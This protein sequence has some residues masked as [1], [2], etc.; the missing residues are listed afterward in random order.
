MNSI[1]ILA[2]DWICNFVGN[3]RFLLALPWVGDYGYRY[4]ATYAQQKWEGGEWWEFEN[5][6]YARVHG[7]GHVSHDYTLI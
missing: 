1:L 6:R 4:A 5:L 7:A 3:E 2:D